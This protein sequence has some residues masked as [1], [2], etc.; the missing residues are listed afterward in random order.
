LGP[1]DRFSD[2]AKR[3]LALAQDEA[4][5]FNHNYIGTEHPLLGL[6][7]EGEG[8]AALVLDSL[9]VELSQVR[10][11]IEFTIGRGD[12]TRSPSEITLA[13]PTKKTI[14]LA[15]DEAR[16]LGHSHVGTE[17]LLL[18]IVRQSESIAAKVLGG[19]GVD[20]ERVRHGV[21]ATLGQPQREVGASAPL[22]PASQPTQHFSGPFD[23]FSDR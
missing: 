1:F 8:V 21:I 2:R 22:P 14:E 23:R 5:R 6:W 17:H 18:G 3:V 16:M 13:P 11:S 15:V 10:R 7:R 19:L 20:L 4:I 9:G 12:A